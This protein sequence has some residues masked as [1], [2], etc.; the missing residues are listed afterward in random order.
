MNFIGFGLNCRHEILDDLHF[1]SFSTAYS[2]YLYLSISLLMFLNQ[3]F[4]RNQCVTVEILSYQHTL[5]R[6]SYKK[7]LDGLSLNWGPGLSLGRA[8]F[9]GHTSSQPISHLVFNIITLA[10]GQFIS[11]CPLGVIV[12]TKKPTKFF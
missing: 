10:K 12:S 8:R 7:N 2:E 1:K 3:N 5:I 9:Y 11:K 6:R 4:Q